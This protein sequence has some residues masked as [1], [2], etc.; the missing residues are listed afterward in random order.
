MKKVYVL[1]FM[2]LG[3]LGAWSQVSLTNGSPSALIDFSNTTPTGV[4]S[5]PS[6]AY[7]AAG[8]EPATVTAGRLNSNAWSTTGFSDGA[9]AFGGTNTAGD[10]AR[11]AT[12]VA[13]TTGGI[14]AFTGAPGSAANPTL[15]IQPGA[16]DFTPGTLT[17]RIQN[18]GTTN[19]T[20]L[21]VSY[22][23]YIRNDQGWSNSFNF[24]YSSDDVTYTPVGA[25]DYAS[26][27][28]ADALGWV[29]VAGAP[30]RSTTI[31]GLAIAPG[32]YVYIRWNGDDVSGA[33]S[34]DEFGLDDINMTATYSAGGTPDILLS[35]D[36]PAVPAGNIIQGTTNN[37]IYD[38]DLVITTADAILNGVTVTTAGS[39]LPADITNIKCWY[40]TDNIFSPGSDVLLSTNA[41]V[42]AAGTQ[43]FPTFIS[44]SILTGATGYIFI[45]ADAA[46]AATVGNTI[47]VNAIT[48]ADISFV[49]GNKSGT[50][51]AGG[52][53]T[54]T[55][56]TVNDVTAP[57]ASVGN[58]SSNLTWT[59]PAGCYS[60]IMIVASQGSANSGGAPSGDG[61]AYTNNLNYGAGTAYGNGFVVYK[62]S[63]SG[64]IVTGLTNGTPYFYK[65]FTRFGTSW[66]TG[67]EISQT[68]AVVTSATDYFRSV[69][70]GSWATLATWQSSTDSITWM[71][72]TIVP[73]ALAA[74][75]VIQSPDSV[76]L[77]AA[78]TTQN[79]TIRTGAVMNAGANA[80]VATDRFN[81]LGTASF[82]Q[83]GTLTAIP[84][85]VQV[86]SPTSNYRFN[87]VQNGASGAFPEFGNFIWEPTP[88]GNNTFQ[89]SI[90]T[91]PFYNGLVIRGNMIINIQG[92]TPREVRFATGG[93]TARSHV[94]DGNLNIISSS[95][96]VIIQN[97]TLAI[98]SNVTV[99]GNINI[100]A[101]ILRGVTSSGNGIVKLSGS[102]NNTG[103][104]IESGVGS[105]TFSINYVGTAA[106]SINNTGGTFS[107]LANQVDTLNNSGPGLTLNT[108]IT[109]G[110]TIH[111]ISGLLTTTTINLLTMDAGSTVFGASNTSFVN[112]P[113]SKIGNTD[114]VF[115]LG[116]T[117]CGPSGT[118]NGYAQLQISNSVGGAATDRYTAEYIRNNTNFLAPKALGLNRV[119]KCDYWT[120]DQNAGTSTLNVTLNWQDAI[121]NCTYASPFVSTLPDLVVVHYNGT[122][123]DTYGPVSTATG[124]T[125]TGD[126]TWP[127]VSVFSPFAIGSVSFLNP[128]PITINYFNGTKNNGSHLLNWKVT[129]IS[130]PSA[131][132]E[133][134]RSSDGVNF[135]SIYSIFATALRCTQPFDYTDNQPA[136]G[137][138]YYRL[139]MTSVDGKVTYSSIVSLINAVKGIDILNI[140][141]NPIVQGTFNL[142]VSSADKT[143][144]EWLITDMQGRVLQKQTTNLIAGFNSLP[145][146]VKNLAA[147]TYQLFGY[148]ADGKTRVLRFVIQ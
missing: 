89:N 65:F 18:N 110:G 25:I 13:Q 117:N 17:L 81:L 19:M 147:G 142:K 42:G 137:V 68:P 94:I 51:F 129:C 64:Q 34:R 85:V 63:T 43:V 115:P 44:Q 97:G 23:I 35:S 76:W 96:I 87:G 71:A 70:S 104:T 38:F 116:K 148:T 5:N 3:S 57:A 31:T 69:S 102:I 145:I 86:L 119:S 62:G 27:V 125:A 80:M 140:A 121:N 123:W 40:S 4:G 112:G 74:H 122:S 30:S 118:V 61:T 37:L 84:G 143:Q 60:E 33:G 93:S 8:F 73:G 92:A 2:V 67:V 21:A 120:L 75:V 7:A 139:K 83:G 55:A 10:H 24:S 124:T 101:G 16:A 146:H 39:Y 95:S 72:A 109:H 22:N 113:V 134:E 98:F 106:Q 9:L 46:C 58:T 48:T 141:P 15:M 132:L 144:M 79:L 138:N 90:T 108:P 12:A 131:T 103:G 130:T 100:S 1:M 107:F 52:T 82:Y 32:S 91:A 28:A 114:F 105:G 26:P 49:S 45:S 54:F 53:Q 99:G 128:L 66:S 20:Q 56:A 78:T 88:T 6:T 126:V 59:N 29:V 47:S 133:M 14:W 11:G 50:A 36:N 127:G 41:A 111:F 77:T 135:N 136:K